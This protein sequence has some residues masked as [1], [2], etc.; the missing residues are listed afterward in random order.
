MANILI[1][2]S[3]RFI[4][5]EMQLDYGLIPPVLLPLGTSTSLDYILSSFSYD[6]CLIG[7]HDEFNRVD[8]YIKNKNIEAELVYIESDN[9]LLSNQLG[10]SILKILES[11]KLKDGDNLIINFGD[12]IVFNRLNLI[13]GFEEQT[14]FIFTSS[15]EDQFRWT[16]ISADAKVH[17]YDKNIINRPQVGNVI[18]GVL[19]IYDAFLFQ[20]ILRKELENEFVVFTQTDSFYLALEKYLN[21]RSKLELVPINDND[22]IDLGHLDT[23]YKSKA[24]FLNA[25][26]FNSFEIDLFWGKIK[27]LSNYTK[28]FIDEIN[29]YVNL[30]AR[31]K[32]L[33]PTIYS[34]SVDVEPFFVEM[35]YYSYP[36]LNQL[37]LFS[38]ISISQWREIFKKLLSI[39]REFSKIERRVD[40]VFIKAFYFDKTK[41]RLLELKKDSNF[42]RFFESN[43]VLNKKEYP[44]LTTLLE[45]LE[46][47]IDSNIT[48]FTTT[49]GVIHGDFCLSNILYDIKTGV[50]KLI[51]PRGSFIDS[52]VFGDPRY[53][54]AKI[55]HSVHGFYDLILNDSYSLL[56]HDNAMSFELTIYKSSQQEELSSLFLNLMAENG[57]VN[58]QILAIESLLFLSMVPLHSDDL[59]RQKAFLMRGLELYYSL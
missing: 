51:D 11:C 24:R 42:L 3:A 9:Q 17:I 35:E 8:D 34:Y 57:V 40:D 53:D 44:S 4:A 27:K 48:Y 7:L 39:Q 52:S 46:S 41:Q 29:W 10:F 38:N 30:P 37:Y 23:F 45:N 47:F 15:I 56:E 59:K 13:S 50:V 20:T 55:S 14:D 22:W 16:T 49:A 43:I 5:A 21:Y 33:I 32:S 58:R 18:T 28:K 31:L 25:R 19:H 2:P 26:H 36:T 1:I 12:T 6:R 54:L